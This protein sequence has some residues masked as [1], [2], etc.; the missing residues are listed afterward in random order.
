M[1]ASAHCQDRLPPLRQDQFTAAQRTAAELAAAGPREGVIGPLVALLRSPELMTRVRGVGGYFLW[2]ETAL[3]DDVRELTI[4]IVARQW[5]QQYEWTY[6]RGI[7]ERVGVPAAV[8]A[9]LA[10]GRRP[11]PLVG[12]LLAAYDLV[13]ELL[14]QH[15]VSDRSYQRALAQ[16]GEAGV[17]ELTTLAGYYTTLAMIM[18]M[19]GTPVPEGAGER[20]RSIP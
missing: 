8:C 6:H 13:T 18:N 1:I 9:D 7:A 5:T 14:R 10:E 4:L 19:A 17:V 16:F 2:G 11:E 3:P 15:A 12:H 20:L